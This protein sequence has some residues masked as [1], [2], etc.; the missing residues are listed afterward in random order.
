MPLRG[1]VTTP[2][3][4]PVETAVV[5]N[6]GRQISR[7]SGSGFLFTGWC[8]VGPKLPEAVARLGG[9]WSNPAREWIGCPFYAN[10]PVPRCIQLHAP[11]HRTPCWRS[12]GSGHFIV[13]GQR[14]SSGRDYFIAVVSASLGTAKVQGSPR[15]SPSHVSLAASPS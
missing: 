4:R 1:G 12:Q 3:R 5:H 15:C 11:P 7:R 9:E 8:N 2:G 6:G 14:A 13:P 10:R